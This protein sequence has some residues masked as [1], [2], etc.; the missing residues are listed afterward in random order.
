LGFASY[1]FNELCSFGPGTANTFRKMVGLPEVVWSKDEDKDKNEEED[2]KSNLHG[3]S[4]QDPK[5]ST[6]SDFTT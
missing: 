3:N 5:Q 4:I 1:I 6:I 2:D